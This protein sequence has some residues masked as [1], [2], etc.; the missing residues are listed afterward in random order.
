MSPLATLGLAGVT[1][2]LTSAA[3]ATV[4]V[5]FGLVTDPT[6]AV[7]FAEPVERVLAKPLELIVAVAGVSEFH[8]AVDVRFAVDPSVYVPVAANCSVK[9]L[10]ILTL[11]G[12]TAMLTSAGAATVNVSVGLVTDPTV[13]VIFVVPIASVLA[14]PPVLIVALLVSLDAQVTPELRSA[15]EESVNVP[16]AVNCCEFPFATDG[17]LGVT[18]MLTSVASVTTKLKFG[19]VV[20]PTAAVMFVEPFA[21]VVAKPV[22][23][24]VAV[25]G[26]SEFHSAE[27]VRSCVLASV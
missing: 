13:A 26:V 12:V 20:D 19:L 5:A 23:S 24:I 17:L 2:K 16:T 11:S 18:A 21:T 1:P 22:E 7:I 8:V 9:P 10:A 4:R 15:V 14:K 6:V 27:A 3:F 25:P